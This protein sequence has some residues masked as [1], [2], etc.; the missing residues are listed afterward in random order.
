MDSSL[1]IVLP[2]FND[3]PSFLAL[4]KDLNITARE[5]G[6]RLSVVVSDDGSTEPAPADL[7]SIGPLSNIDSVLHVRLALNLGHQRALAVGL[8]VA[9]EDCAAQ[10][11]VIMDADGEDRPLDIPLLMASADVFPREI[12][13]AERRRRSEPLAFRMFYK[14]Y[15]A[16][17]VVLTGKVVSFGNFSLLSREHAERLSM[18]SEL[19]NNLPAAIMRSRLPINF[20][21]I[22]R[23]K[24][25][26]GSSKMSFVQLSL[27]GISA[28][29]VYT[30]AI[31]VRLLIVTFILSVAGVCLSAVV[32]SLRLFLP[33]HA[34]PGWATTV[35]F[36]TAIII[37][38]AM[39]TTL[40]TA[41]LL[42][43]NRSQRHFIPAIECVH[44]IRSRTLMPFY[45]L[46]PEAELA[47][48]STSV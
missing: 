22:D 37:F 9:L 13:V 36:G 41:L 42:L 39:F 48:R 14:A 16:A 18:V 33:S 8:C 17:F 15:K 30:D 23:G 40:M 26:F 32:L 10:R 46:V 45:N 29:S 20:V 21:P 1:T 5:Q 43:S 6:Y 25:Y 4:L 7:Y 35:I 47:S 34:T 38:Q 27:H 31:L 2:V 28:Y 11:F 12:A 3:W 44:Y 19:W 24:R